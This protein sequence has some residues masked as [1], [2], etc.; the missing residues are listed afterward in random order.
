MDFTEFFGELP[1]MSPGESHL[2]QRQLGVDRDKAPT[3]STYLGIEAI[4]GLARCFQP[5]LPAAD[6]NTKSG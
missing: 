4:V 3:D 5:G 1:Q 6:S 2:G